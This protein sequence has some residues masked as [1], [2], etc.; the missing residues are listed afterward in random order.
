M[1][2]PWMPL[3]RRFVGLKEIR[4]S[5]HEPEIVRFFKESGFPDVRDDET[6]WCAAFVNA[7]LLRAGYKGSGALTARSFVKL[8]EKLAKPRV[9]C[10]VVVRRGASWQGHVGF[11]LE[12]RGGFVRLLSGNQA[13]AVTDTGWYPKEKIVAYRWPTER[14]K[15]LAR[16]KIAA[17]GAAIGAGAG[18][19]AANTAKETIEALP[20]PAP[21]VPSAGEVLDGV[22]TAKQVAEQLGLLDYAIALL[23]NPRFLVAVAVLVVALAIIYWRWRDHGK[24]MFSWWK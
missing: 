14:V 6:P 3:A 8:G 21:E 9:G 17:G 2:A 19:D 11:F 5:K 24:G 15:S 13:N 22:T 20:Q 18:A 23:Q 16:S 4:G 10:I 12:E 1:T 7:M